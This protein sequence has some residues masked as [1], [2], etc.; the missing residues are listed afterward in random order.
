VYRWLWNQKF[1]RWYREKYRSDREDWFLDCLAKNTSTESGWIE[2]VNSEMK[3]IAGGK[4]RQDKTI[5]LNTSCSLRITLD[6]PQYHCLLFNRC[7]NEIIPLCPS[8][9]FA[10]ETTIEANQPIVIPQSNAEYEDLTFEKVG[11]EEF[12]AIV[13]N[14]TLVNRNLSVG[15]LFD[16][17]PVRR[18]AL[19]GDSRQFKTTLIE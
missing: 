15:D 19:H 17:L 14:S 11:K 8:L 18:Y 1:I 3:R 7:D 5:S 2:V 12:I 4:R 9:E 13:V 10:P 6:Y 16:I